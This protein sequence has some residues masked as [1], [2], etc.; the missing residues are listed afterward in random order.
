METNES[1]TSIMEIFWC[2]TP[3]MV[4]KCISIFTSQQTLAGLSHNSSN[5][6]ECLHLFSSCTLSFHDFSCYSSVYFV[7]LALQKFILAII[8]NRKTTWD[9]DS[10][11]PSSCHQC[12]KMFL[13][14]ISEALNLPFICIVDVRLYIFLC[15]CAWPAPFACSSTAVEDTNW[16][17]HQALSCRPGAWPLAVTAGRAGWQGFPQPLQGCPSLSGCP[18]CPS[19]GSWRSAALPSLGTSRN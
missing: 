2:Y 9:N 7:F 10:S 13:S 12:F 8:A 17:Q 1:E 11:F 3:W 18:L 6:G 14:N 16:E 5:Q 4:V 15:F 19:T